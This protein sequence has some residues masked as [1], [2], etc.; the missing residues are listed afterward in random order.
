M[1]QL[2]I[3][4]GTGRCGTNSL[5]TLLS[6]QPNC[7]CFHEHRPRPNWDNDEVTVTEKI[8]YLMTLWQKYVGDVGMYYLPYVDFLMDK[9]P[10]CKFVCLKRDK[11]QT[12]QSFMKKTPER[13]HWM[14]NNGEWKKDP[15]WDQCF[16]KYDVERKL[17]ALET[18]WDDYYDRSEK[19]A[20][21]YPRNF[22][23]FK[24]EDLNNEKQVDRIL[25]FCKFE[26]KN[27]V[28]NLR[29]NKS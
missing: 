17:E 29:L 19:Y 21:K 25:N 18:Y 11:E 12:V 10:D 28:T 23:I 8:K 22:K 2:I 14:P 5:Q 26:K 27:I 16:P 4:L 13:N 1:K 6:K 3:G 15:N 9:Y 7:T 24:I 20:D